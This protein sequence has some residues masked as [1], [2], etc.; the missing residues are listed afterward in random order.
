M[1]RTLRGVAR[2]DLHTRRGPRK[3]KHK[4]YACAVTTCEVDLVHPQNYSFSD[5]AVLRSSAK[6]LTLWV[7]WKHPQ[8]QKEQKPKAR[9][10]AK[11]SSNLILCSGWGTPALLSL[12]YRV[13][14]K[15]R[16]TGSPLASAALLRWKST[17][18][19]FAPAPRT[20]FPWVY[21]RGSAWYLPF[22]QGLT[23]YYPKQV[24]IG[25]GGLHPNADP[26]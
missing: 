1:S 24:G 8:A 22:S 18:I 15:T 25:L 4:P 10:T 21:V 7:E 6:S 19:N 9:L 12:P 26:G 3:G 13:S 20:H 17:P 5:W 2:T 11:L 14:S 23:P 16:P